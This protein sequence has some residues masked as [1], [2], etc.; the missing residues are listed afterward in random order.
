VK[1]PKFR[2]PFRPRPQG[3]DTGTQTVS[4]TLVSSSFN[5]L[6]RLVALESFIAFSRRE[7]FRSCTKNHCQLTLILTVDK[8]QFSFTLVSQTPNESTS[9]RTIS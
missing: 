8:G 4:E 3:S 6:T 5:H 2:K 7:S 1:K 9:K